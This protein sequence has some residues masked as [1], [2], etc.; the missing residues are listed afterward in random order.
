MG[1]LLLL[2]KT[3]KL[4]IELNESYLHTPDKPY[5]WGGGIKYVNNYDRLPFQHVPKPV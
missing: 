5:L 1:T 3:F 4:N 2:V